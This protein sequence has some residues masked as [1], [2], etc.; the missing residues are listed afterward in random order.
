MRRGI[1]SAVASIPSGTYAPTASPVFTGSVGLPSYT[2]ATLPAAGTAGR[3]V[4][5]SDDKRG[6]WFDTGTEWISVSAVVRVKHFAKGDGSD[7][8]AAIQAA[9]TLAESLVIADS[10]TSKNH[11]KVVV[12]FDEPVTYYG[13][14]S[15]LA[16][17]A[18]MVVLAGTSMGILVLNTT[19]DSD[20]VRLNYGNN[21]SPV[22]NAVRNLT[23][24][25]TGTGSR[26]IYANQLQHLTIDRV[27]CMG[28]PG[29][30][31]YMESTGN[32]LSGCA[33]SVI[34]QLLCQPSGAVVDITDR[35][36]IHNVFNLP[37][38]RECEVGM[39]FVNAVSPVINSPY[40]ESNTRGTA[41][42]GIRF[43]VTDSG[44]AHRTAKITGLYSEANT[45]YAIDADRNYVVDIDGGRAKGGVDTTTKTWK[46]QV[47]LDGGGTVRNFQ[48]YNPTRLT[49]AYGR[50][51]AE[52]CDGVVGKPAEVDFTDLMP[53]CKN[54]VANA[55]VQSWFDADTAW[56]AVGS[57]PPVVAYD[58]AVGFLG[59]RSKKSS[60]STGG[61]GTSFA[62]ARMDNTSVVVGS[63]EPYTTAVAF[64]ASVASE[65]FRLRHVGATDGSII[66][67]VTDTDWQVVVWSTSPV[68][69]A[70]TY[71]VYAELP[72]ALGVATDLWIGAV[73]AG[74]VSNIGLRNTAAPAAVAGGL[75]VARLT[76]GS[77]LI[78]SDSIAAATPA[79]A[80]KSAD[81]SVS[82]ANTGTTLVDATD[83][84]IALGVGET[85]AF[86]AVLFYEGSTAGDLK[87][88][89]SLPA[90]ATLVWGGYAPAPAIAAFASTAQFSIQTGTG[91]NGYGGV[92]AG[93]GLIAIL[94]G[95]IVNPTNAG[96]LQLRFAQL[97][98]DATATILKANSHIV[99][100]K[101]A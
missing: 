87:V 70:G 9:I 35:G 17:N 64:K 91:T 29:P 30:A 101:L 8:R 77:T 89:F 67:V 92:G 65:V 42:T 20:V 21:V 59:A 82:S 60:W 52:N 79:K 49:S 90:G 72:V 93:N 81:Q 95:L 68:V 5:V 75:E 14:S 73:A 83:L 1:A 36:G 88:G 24:K 33:F 71:Y 31:L 44:L 80:V 74:K 61:S 7:E 37:R 28:H 84:A 47:R 32:L 27:N 51:R 34:N 19:T 41:K 56:T 98:S 53:P 2:K 12:L 25:G 85:W 76:V 96:N 69:T 18:D 15:P 97:A 38:V 62:R 11:S 39:D 3:I 4:R 94:R 54:T 55:A 99:A 66:N 50:I 40:V 43:R 78:T 45:N 100:T 26:A 23:L 16:V 58:T 57:T 48:G 86:E 13:I 63:G 6:Q 46:E 22:G 10:F